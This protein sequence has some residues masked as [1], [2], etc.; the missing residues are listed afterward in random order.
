[1]NEGKLMKSAKISVLNGFTALMFMLA[2]SPIVQSQ[3][4][5]EVF[6]TAQ[7]RAKGLQDVSVSVSSLSGD[8]ISEAGIG[9]VEDFAAY[10][11]NL[12]FSETAIGTNL[13]IR[14][15]GS[16]I[17]QGFEQS[18][19][20]YTDGIYYGRA[21]LTRSPIFDME[22]VEVLRGPQVTLFGNNSVGGALS[23]ITRKPSD[24]PEVSL[25]VL[26]EPDHGELEN[27][28][29]MSGPLTDTVSARLA[30]RSYDLDGYLKN[31]TLNRDEPERD[32]DTT[33]LSF[34][35]EPNDSFD[36]NL[37]LERSNF[38]TVGRQIRVFEMLPSLGYGASA[39]NYADNNPVIG[40]NLNQILST[41][42]PSVGG[43]TAANPSAS[44]SR[45]ANGDSSENETNNI[46]L[47]SNWQFDND[48]TLTSILGY[49]DYEYDEVCDCDFTS[50]EMVPLESSEQYEQSSIELRLVSPGAET[51]D[52]IVGIYLQ[53]DELKFED[54][55]LALPEP[56][57]LFDLLSGINLTSFGAAGLVDKSVPRVFEQ[58]NE[59]Q[60]IFGQVTWNMTDYSRL[61]IGVRHT[62]T[63]KNASRS[64]SY[65]QLDGSSITDPN[66]LAGVDIAYAI[67][68][69][70][71][72]HSLKGS[73]EE[74]RTSYNV[75]FEWDYNE[76]V[77]LYTSFKNGFKPGGYDVRSNAPPEKEQAIGTVLAFNSG[78]FEFEDERVQA[79]ELGSKISIGGVAEL[80]VAYFYTEIT[81][82][83]VSLFD[84]ALGFNVSNAAE[85][86][87][88]GIEIDGRW[89]LTDRWL[90][91]AS[92][93]FM[94]FEFQDYKDG[95]CTGA[96]QLAAA[97]SGVGA[98]GDLV[99]QGTECIANFSGK[100][101]QYVADYSGSLSL[102]YEQT[103]FDKLVFRSALD[104]VFTDD[105]SPA[106]NLDAVVQ[107]Q[108]YEKFN[109]RFAIMDIDEQW[110][111][112]LLGRN[113]FDQ[114]IVSY[115]NDVPLSTSQLGASSYYGFFERPRSWALQL[116]YRFF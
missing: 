10:V 78:A 62:Q 110:E 72:R 98:N 111:I 88:Q 93:G 101:N 27:I 100:T 14:G 45:Y 31:E 51:L 63:E 23:L 105:Y 40:L 113:I 39:Q 66:E 24:E 12:S 28:I 79:F 1:M 89:A 46:T 42:F 73:R 32:Y 6:V 80:N 17:N 64:L 3:V 77:L 53:E 18:V 106:Q 47:T 96:Q 55:L 70:A 35:F 97:L 71:H 83:Q 74:K 90:L 34:S 59:N 20:M 33:R 114:E 112:A 82:M 2:L 104:M 102:S 65:S 13:Y 60:S 87:S 50:A 9:K 92:I 91:S 95:L 84:G 56:S 22:R 16:G 19:G 76:D 36:T 54:A 109:L 68:F 94:D 75:T 48:W 25:S 8:K 115:A 61:L 49:M 85:A 103:L 5:E 21:Q 43:A 107:Q 29:I 41:Q 44:G 7:I 30:Y 58:D 38:D 11:P 37:K 86:V 26:Y 81:D 99:S 69:K 116:K 52:Y 67:L 108:A 15:V 57:G 4:L